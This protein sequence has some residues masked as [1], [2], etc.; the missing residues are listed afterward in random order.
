MRDPNN[1]T[2]E[3]IGHTSSGLPKAV[4]DRLARPY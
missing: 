2:L 1:E 3:L 4:K